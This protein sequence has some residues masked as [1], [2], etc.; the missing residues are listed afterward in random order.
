MA[1]W[2]GVIIIVW[3][4]AFGASHLWEMVVASALT[5]ACAA[6]LLRKR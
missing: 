2:P 4:M 3:V 5:L 1:L 6:M